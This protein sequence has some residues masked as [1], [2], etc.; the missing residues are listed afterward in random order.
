MSSIALYVE[1]PTKTQF[2]QRLAN[3][4]QLAITTDVNAYRYI[5]AIT[6]ARIELRL[7]EPHIHPVYVDFLAPSWLYR[8][9]HATRSSELIARAIGLKKNYRP[10][11]VDVT[12][13]LGADA[14]IIVAL[15][16]TVTMIERSPI[17]ATLL[18]DGLSRAQQGRP[19]LFSKLEFRPGDA[20]NVLESYKTNDQRPAVIYLDPMFPERTKS[21]LVKKEMR[22]LKELV[23]SDLDSPDLFNLALQVASKR[24]VVKRPLYAPTLTAQTPHLVV[25]GKTLRFDVY[26]VS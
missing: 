6:A 16:C 24:V 5:L 21:A 17:V 2:A 1:D 22:M 11:V 23:G 15:G 26:L 4:L 8:L 12:A 10:H 7:N 19:E 20:I 9:E 14:S 18:Q 25:K 3:Q 13:G